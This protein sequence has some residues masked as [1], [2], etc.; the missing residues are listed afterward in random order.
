MRKKSVRTM[1]F[2]VRLVERERDVW[3]VFFTK[4]FDTM[5]GILKRIVARVNW[6]IFFCFVQCDQIGRFLGLWATFL[7]LWQQLVCPNLPHSQTIL[8]KVSKC[9]IFL[10]KSFLV[11][12]YRHLAIFFWSHW[13]RP[14]ALALARSLTDCV[15]ST[16]CLSLKRFGK[17]KMLK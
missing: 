6:V 4:R 15:S 9:L 2:C 14:S 5:I 12:F 17:I 8:V 16:S 13:F 1:C 7:S 10:V 11:K 3:R